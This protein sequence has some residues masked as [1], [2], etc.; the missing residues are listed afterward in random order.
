MQPFGAGSD[1]P[2]FK[3]GYQMLGL[4]EKS[5]DFLRNYA[6]TSYEKSMSKSANNN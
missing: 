2:Y 6:K 1:F 5:E 4:K 3:A